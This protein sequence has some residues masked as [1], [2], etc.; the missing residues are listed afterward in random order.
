MK[1]ELLKIAQESLSSDEIEKIVREKFA[2]ALGDAV[3][4]AFRWGDVKHVIEGKV[5]AVMIP[6]IEE[7][8]FS[9]Y[10]PKLD[11]VLTEIVNSD[12]CAGNRQILENFKNLMTEPEQKE[13][14]VT[15]IFRAWIKWC[16]KDIDTDDLEICY[17]DGAS[18]S[19]VNCEMRIEELD[20]PSWS[21]LQRSVIVFENAHDESLNIE[22]PIEK[23]LR[24][25]GEETNY[26]LSGMHDI[27]L[28][29]LR[30]MNEFQILLL[31]MERA[32]TQII[33]DKEFD[34]SYIQPEKEP[35]ASYS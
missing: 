17:D 5:K 23:W 28:S 14:N 34:D 9:S 8:D 22:I 3:E 2:K 20:K 1:D 7:Y 15:D 33:I 35:E 6:Y 26:R 27:S 19:S 11:S 10:L 25:T 31:K 24:G 4:N 13:I 32:R 29:S 12:F 16:E 18:Y 30:T 21:K